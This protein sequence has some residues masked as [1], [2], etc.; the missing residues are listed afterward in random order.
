MAQALCKP[1]QKDRISFH[2]VISQLCAT[3]KHGVLTS[4]SQQVSFGCRLLLGYGQVVLRVL[5]GNACVPF[6]FHMTELCSCHDSAKFC[7]DCRIP[8]EHRV[9]FRGKEQKRG[10]NYHSSNKMLYCKGQGVSVRRLHST[11]TTSQHSSNFLP[12]KYTYFFCVSIAAASC[13][14]LG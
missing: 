3:C 5:S 7:S 11:I 12:I 8:S 10:I 2:I 6:C 1:G 13:D 4:Y 14:F 9:L